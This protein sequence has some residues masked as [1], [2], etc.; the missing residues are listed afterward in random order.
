[1]EGSSPLFLTTRWTLL[2]QVKAPEGGAALDELCRRYW[3]PVYSFLRRSGCAEA[4]AEDLTQDFFH[5]FM[6]RD[7]F[8]RAEREKGRFRSFLLGCVR[9]HFANARKAASR[10]KR[11]GG[12]EFV[13]VNEELDGG[14]GLSPEQAFDKRWA[15]DLV[16]RALLRLKAEWEEN[17][18]P[19]DVLAPFLS[20]ERGAVSLAETA[21]KLG[22]SLAATKSA[23]HRLRKRLGDLVKEEVSATLGSEDD[24][25]DELEHLL[26][27][28]SR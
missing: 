4:D 19:F 20:G 15:E 12:Y 14:D 10:Q 13:E 1:M 25:S 8:S 18:R 6:E 21:D 26:Q 23:V 24:A 5:D 22:V 7:G 16:D 2:D 3:G 27:L 28:L 17:G 11:G 9:N